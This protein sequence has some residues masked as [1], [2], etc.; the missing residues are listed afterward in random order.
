MP[1]D[2]E[3]EDP[4]PEDAPIDLPEAP[5][6]LP[7]PQP[8]QSATIDPGSIFGGLFGV[9]P[10]PGSSTYGEG[11]P[12]NQRFGDAN[13]DWKAGNDPIPAVRVM[14]DGGGGMLGAALRGAFGAIQMAAARPD[15]M[16]NAGTNGAPSMQESLK[17]LF[18]ADG[19]LSKDKWA[20]QAE[21]SYL[22][23][24]YPQETK[25]GVDRVY[26][27]GSGE[28][29]RFVTEPYYRKPAEVAGRSYVPRSGAG[30]GDDPTVLSDFGND[31]LRNDPKTG[32]VLETYK[33]GKWVAA[34]D[35]KGAPIVVKDPKAVVADMNA[36]RAAAANRGYTNDQPEIQ[37]TG[38]TVPAR[39]QEIPGA[40]GYVGPVLRA[41]ERVDSEGTITNS[42]GRITGH[43]GTDGKRYDGPRSLQNALPFGPYSGK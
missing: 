10:T 30:T 9:G 37:N 31:R 7:A 36:R 34:T 11:L 26:Q 32:P 40:S 33:D 39:G 41:G 29:K 23:R 12:D 13:N 24:V 15:V 4:K 28:N 21:Q 42:Q 16:D 38:T 25:D 20:D 14:L 27:Y 35:A 19:K 18:G 6:D 1:Y 8:V 22:T 43:L 2:P 5:V 17:G 3:Q